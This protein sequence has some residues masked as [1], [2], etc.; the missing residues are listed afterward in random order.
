MSYWGTILSVK[1][2]FRRHKCGYRGWW[3]RCLTSMG[4]V[5]YNNSMKKFNYTFFLSFNSQ[6]GPSSMNLN[7]KNGYCWE[8]IR[9]KHFFL[10][11]NFGTDILSNVLKRHI[12]RRCRWST[13]RGGSNPWKILGL[14]SYLFLN[15]FY[16]KNT[17]IIQCVFILL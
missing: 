15:Y 11:N 6:I 8:K 10:M 2:V 7:W 14:S 12:D 5:M 1:N 13:S 17:A 3:E 4:K 16:G 9:N